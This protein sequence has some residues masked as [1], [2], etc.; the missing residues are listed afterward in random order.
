MTDSN[1]MQFYSRYSLSKSQPYVLS[2]E[3]DKGAFSSIPG[4]T[5]IPD[6]SLVQLNNSQFPS[7]PEKVPIRSQSERCSTCKRFVGSNGFVFWKTKS[8]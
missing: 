3:F 8:Q 4:T 7:G 6:F 1:K 2:S 5:W